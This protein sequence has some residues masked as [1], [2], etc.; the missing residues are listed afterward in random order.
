M[1]QEYS[2]FQGVL[3]QWD[4]FQA[5]KIDFKKSLKRYDDTKT[6]KIPTVHLENMDIYQNELF[7]QQPVTRSRNLAQFMHKERP[8]ESS[9][10]GTLQKLSSFSTYRKSSSHSVAGQGTRHQKEERK[11]K[12]VHQKRKKS[13]NLKTYFSRINLK[14]DVWGS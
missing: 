1:W 8:S 6:W 11:K 9:V 7:L 2:H 4:V 3:T 14:R 12:K 13:K 5:L 10:L